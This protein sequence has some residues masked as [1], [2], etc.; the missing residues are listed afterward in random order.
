MR[1][2]GPVVWPPGLHRRS[3]C[4]CEAVP[5]PNSAVCRAA[6]PR[7]GRR[8]RHPVPSRRGATTWTMASSIEELS[9]S[10]TIDALAEQERAVTSLRTRAGTVVATASISGSF[11]GAR[12]SHTSLDLWAVLALVAFVLCLASAIWILLP[13]KMVFA[14]RGEALLAESDRA[15]VKDVRPIAQ[16]AV[17]SSRTSTQTATRSDLCPLGSRSAARSWPSR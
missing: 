15:G 17:G 14:F 10:L 3:V 8:G 16:P 13:H 4:L 6:L 9:Y 2:A 1:A 5:R 12:S 7:R 11:L